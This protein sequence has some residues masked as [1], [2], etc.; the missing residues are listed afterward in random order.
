MNWSLL[1]AESKSLLLKCADSTDRL[2]ALSKP[3]W[4]FREMGW[5]L[6]ER[7]QDAVKTSACAR[8]AP[9]TNL[10]GRGA[11]EAGAAIVTQQP[12]LSSQ[13]HAFAMNEADVNPEIFTS[14]RRSW[15]ES[16]GKCRK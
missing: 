16:R 5:E 6:A 7:K 3:A 10:S 1:G 4:G 13:C 14:S 2:E 11:T 8:T 9:S 12:N 15:G